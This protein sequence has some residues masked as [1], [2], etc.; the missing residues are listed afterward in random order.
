MIQEKT[1]ECLYEL[2]FTPELVTEDI[3]YS[4][5]MEGRTFLLETEDEDVK[6]LTLTLPNIHTVTEENRMDVLEAMVKLCHELRYV[7]PY[8]LFESVWIHYQHYLGDSVPTA[9]L[10]EHM[11]RTLMAAHCNFSNLLCNDNTSDL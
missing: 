4:F 11:I 5:K 1:L 8:I 6:C 3:G 7:Q 2:G 9:Q 10:V